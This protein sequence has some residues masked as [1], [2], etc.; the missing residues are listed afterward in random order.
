[1]FEDVPLLTGGRHSDGSAEVLALI[2]GRL[3]VSV[4]GADDY[5]VHGIFVDDPLSQ[6]PKLTYI[7]AR[8]P[9]RPVILA[10]V[11]AARDRRIRSDV[12]RWREGAA[13]AAAD[14]R[15][16]MRTA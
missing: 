3:E 8:H 13:E 16:G 4:I 5:F 12:E 1:V 6:A 9:L 7:H 15:R 11:V 14:L 10:S 2:S